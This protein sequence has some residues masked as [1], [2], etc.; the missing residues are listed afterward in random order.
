MTVLRCATIWG[1]R[2][3]I[4]SLMWCLW[5][6]LA[7]PIKGRTETSFCK[8][9]IIALI[10][11]ITNWLTNWLTNCRSCESVRVSQQKYPEHSLTKIANNQWSSS[12]WQ[13]YLTYINLSMSEMVTKW[14]DTWDHL[15]SCLMN[16][17]LIHLNKFCVFCDISTFLTRQRRDPRF[18]WCLSPYPLKSL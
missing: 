3:S 8:S 10:I 16:R 7:C 18:S 2:E 1:W 12:R 15:W 6:C 13:G 11:L 14:R 9:S 5:L 4:S 17:N